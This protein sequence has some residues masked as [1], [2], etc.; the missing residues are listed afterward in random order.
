LLPGFSY[1]R[2]FYAPAYD[3]PNEENIMP[4]KRTTIFWDPAIRTNNLGQAQIEFFNSDD[5]RKLQVEIQ[6]VT[7]Y[8]DIINAI[9]PVGTVLIK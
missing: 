2:E 3:V 9:L 1:T 6:G 4:D 5:A 8:G 7:D